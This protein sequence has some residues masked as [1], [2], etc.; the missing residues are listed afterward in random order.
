MRG[1]K[2]ALL[3]LGELSLSYILE[4][5][6]PSVPPFFHFTSTS[7]ILRDGARVLLRPIV[8]ADEP[9][10]IGFHEGLSEESVRSRY[11]GMLSLGFR[12]AHER[13]A[14]ICTTDPAAEIALVA[15]R[16]IEGDGHGNGE[17]LGV[18]RLMRVPEREDEAEFAMLVADRWHGKGL[19]RALLAALVGIG[20]EARVRIVCH[21]LPGNHAMLRVCRQVGFE[22]HFNR[23]GDEWFGEMDLRPEPAKRHPCA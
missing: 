13:L 12:T 4:L 19:G 15:E 23:A 5:L 11:F 18:G 17:I 3:L 6:G 8:P 2:F 22:V 9:R 7:I 10:M 14:A 16:L 1:I 20:R 21:V